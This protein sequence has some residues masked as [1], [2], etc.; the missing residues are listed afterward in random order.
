MKLREEKEKGASSG[1]KEKQLALP[2]K[3][4]DIIR[5]GAK[6]RGGIFTTH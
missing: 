6:T 2:K 1:K 3:Q 4:P 5:R